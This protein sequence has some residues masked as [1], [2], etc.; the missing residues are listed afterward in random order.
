MTGAIGH[1]S[2]GERVLTEKDARTLI[3]NITSAVQAM[4]AAE[5]PEVRAER[6]ERYDA[7]RYVMKLRRQRYTRH[8][9]HRGKKY[10]R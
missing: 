10:K 7:M 9:I 8:H 3:T 6:Q 4:I 5:P 1:L 2:A